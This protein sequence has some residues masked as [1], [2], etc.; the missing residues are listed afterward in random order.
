[1]S[2]IVYHNIYFKVSKLFSAV[3]GNIQVVVS[4]E[5]KFSFMFLFTCFITAQAVVI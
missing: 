4:E 3:S 1:M 5:K 2:I